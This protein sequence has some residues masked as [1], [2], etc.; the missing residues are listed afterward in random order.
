MTA[1]ESTWRLSDDRKEIVLDLNEETSKRIELDAAEADRMIQTL[2]AL[3]VR[4]DPPIPSRDPTPGES[5]TVVPKG[6]WWVQPDLLT[7]GIVLAV[8]HPGYGWVGAQLDHPQTSQLIQRILQQ[9]P[10]PGPSRD[11]SN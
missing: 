10:M 1:D 11:S 4:M 3:R 7:G 9:R 6:R 2:T 8:L 5:M